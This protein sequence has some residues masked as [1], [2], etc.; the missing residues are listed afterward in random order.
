MLESLCIAKGYFQLQTLQFFVPLHSLIVHA[1]LDPKN[2]DMLPPEQLASIQNLV[3]D[4]AV[5]D[6]D[7]ALHVVRALTEGDSA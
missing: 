7:K 5:N 2:D 1:I 4:K 6:S 3:I